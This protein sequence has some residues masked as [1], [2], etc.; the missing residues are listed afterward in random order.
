MALSQNKP[1][2]TLTKK[3]IFHSPVSDPRIVLPRVSGQGQRPLDLRPNRVSSLPLRTSLRFA[4]CM[5][6]GGLKRGPPR[7]NT[8]FPSHT[9]ISA[10]LLSEVR[11]AFW[12]LLTVDALVLQC[13]PL[14]CSSWFNVQIPYSI[15]ATWNGVAPGSC[16][17]YGFRS[18]TVRMERILLPSLVHND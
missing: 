9:V 18:V 11:C 1:H 2:E 15:P 16:V 17:C 13:S 14:I 12:G 4:E 10:L 6:G 5:Q 7:A 8:A 3:S